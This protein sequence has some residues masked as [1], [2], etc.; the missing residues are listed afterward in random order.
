LIVVRKTAVASVVM[1]LAAACAG[2]VRAGGQPVAFH[3]GGTDVVGVNAKG[4]RF[5]VP[6]FPWISRA[7]QIR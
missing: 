7:E 5:S 4:I 6:T 1:L 3:S 2:G